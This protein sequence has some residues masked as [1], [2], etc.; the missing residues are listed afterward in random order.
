MKDHGQ[1]KKAPREADG[2]ALFLLHGA[3]SA[4]KTKPE[5]DLLSNVCTD[6]SIGHDRKK[7]RIFALERGRATNLKSP[8]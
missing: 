4:S 3:E 8:G 2:G 7:E 6:R 1:I 5:K